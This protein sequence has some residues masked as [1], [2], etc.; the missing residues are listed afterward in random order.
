MIDQNILLLLEATLIN[1][2]N[3]DY[4]EVSEQ[5]GFIYILISKKEYENIP[6]HERIMRISSLLEF[7]HDDILDKYPV[8]IECY[9][10][11]ELTDLFNLYGKN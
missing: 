11:K 6:L 8:I 7:E 3:P 10:E 5:A 2:E 1:E 9:D 4:I